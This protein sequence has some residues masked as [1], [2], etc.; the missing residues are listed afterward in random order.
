MQERLMESTRRARQLR[1]Q[2]R[3]LLLA[4]A[5]EVQAELEQD[6]RWSLGAC[7]KIIPIIIIIYIFGV[8]LATSPLIWQAAADP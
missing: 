4:R 8:L 6:L 3:Q 7:M 2:H 1:K 5:R